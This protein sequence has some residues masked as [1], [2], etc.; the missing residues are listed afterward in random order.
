MSTS[1]HVEQFIATL[2]LYNGVHQEN[3]PVKC[4]PPHTPLLYCK[5]EV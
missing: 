5:T 1:V 4:L 3:M 2:P